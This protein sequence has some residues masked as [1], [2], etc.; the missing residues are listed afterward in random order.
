MV[1]EIQS[2]LQTEPKE[3]EES[4]FQFYGSLSPFGRF[5]PFRKKNLV[6]GTGASFWGLV[7]RFIL[8][9][10]KREMKC[11]K[12]GKR[13][14]QKFLQL[15]FFVA[16]PLLLLSLPLLG[17]LLHFFFVRNLWAKKDF[18]SSRTSLLPPDVL[19]GEVHTDV[20]VGIE[21]LV[22]KPVDICQR[23]FNRPKKHSTGTL[24][25]LRSF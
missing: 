15:L 7:F 16:V 14:F 9:F 18:S 20:D 24:S 12:S 4:S 17:F 13:G 8:F 10:Q 22:S 25:F 19:V 1:H 5:L 11:G 2:L 21:V 23:C 3:N 6:L